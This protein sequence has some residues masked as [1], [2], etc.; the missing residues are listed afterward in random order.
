[1]VNI[2]CDSSMVDILYDNLIMDSTC[3]SLSGVRYEV[4]GRKQT[5]GQKCIFLSFL[6]K[7]RSFDP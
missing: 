2:L 5:M 1:M 7:T 6:I 3:D 4:E